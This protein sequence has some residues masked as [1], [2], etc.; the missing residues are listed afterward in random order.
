[1]G[2]NINIKMPK[3][4]YSSNK[5]KNLFFNKIKTKK[6]TEV[7][8]FYNFSYAKIGPFTMRAISKIIAHL[9]MEIV[10]LDKL[11]QTTINTKQKFAKCSKKNSTVPM[12]TDV[13]ICI[14]LSK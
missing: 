10:S 12:V 9:H 6:K 7:I 14:L 4:S 3:K 13:S 11:L 5:E 1:M 2:P 8:Y